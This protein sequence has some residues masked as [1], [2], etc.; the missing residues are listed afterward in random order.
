MVAR[1]AWNH[2]WVPRDHADRMMALL[3]SCQL[4]PSH[5]AA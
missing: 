3:R 5:L 4:W 1:R 2:L